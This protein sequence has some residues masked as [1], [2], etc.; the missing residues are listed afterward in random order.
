MFRGWSRLC[1]HAASLSSAEAASATA[2][3]VARAVRAEAMDKEAKAAVEKEEALG[4][5]AAAS[6]EVAKERETSQHEAVRGSL[7]TAEMRG[8]VGEREHQL[9]RM[10]VLVRTEA[11]S[12]FRQG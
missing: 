1:L 5:V 12:K 7:L 9:R 4:R 2:T 10:K 11:F 8:N 6:A 3:A